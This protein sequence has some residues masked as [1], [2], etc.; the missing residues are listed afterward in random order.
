LCELHQLLPGQRRV[1]EIT[2]PSI[3]SR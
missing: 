1:F 2:Q 3:L